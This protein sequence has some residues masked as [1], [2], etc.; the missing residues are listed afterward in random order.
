MEITVLAASGATGLQLTRQ[1]LDR[2]HTV[3][4]IA[5]TP[6]RI[7]VPD[8]PRLTRVAADVREPNSIA[9]ALHD[10]EVVV[11][12]LG[13][14]GRDKP[15]V[16]TA[17][18]RALSHGRVVWLGAY[19]TGPSASAAG[20]VTRGLLRL[21][22]DQI[23]DKVAADA[24]VLAAGGTVFHAAILTDGPLSP[25]RRTV[26]LGDAPKRL[27]PA[28]VSRATVAAALLDEAEN[29]AYAGSIAL[30]LER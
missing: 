24:L 30:P 2:G 1:A 27:L 5:R 11:S 12:G 23:A 28:C 13:I 16:L 7:A 25:D 15:G 6:G 10:R 29:P 4:A 21:L 22:G 8:H 17:G 20:P 9:A 19:G 26:K 18:A 14:A 3:V